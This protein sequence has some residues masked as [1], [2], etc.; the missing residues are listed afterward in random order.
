MEVHQHQ[1]LLQPGGAVKVINKI[2]VSG[3]AYANN[4]GFESLDGEYIN[5]G[6]NKRFVN[7][8]DVI[9][10]N[11]VIKWVRTNEEGLDWAKP[12]QDS[13]CILSSDE[14]MAIVQLGGTENDV[15]S[16]ECSNTSITPIVDNSTTASVTITVS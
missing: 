8:N 11:A 15:Q 10:T 6:S 3:F 12:T 5:D 16:I 4:T 13:W 1:L 14:T 2:T 7:G 9:G